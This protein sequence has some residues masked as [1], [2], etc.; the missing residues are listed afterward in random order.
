MIIIHSNAIM[1]TISM[2]ILIL[3]TIMIHSNAKTCSSDASFW[4]IVDNDTPLLPTA[5]DKLINLPWR[6][7][8]VYYTGL[9]FR[10]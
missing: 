8:H 9:G 2:I 3:M 6:L 1:I 4:L 7:A 5:T 10:V